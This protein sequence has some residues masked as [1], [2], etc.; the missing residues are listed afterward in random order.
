M[1][2][3]NYAALHLRP[4]PRWMSFLERPGFSH[5]T[6]ASPPEKEIIIIVAH[7]T[8]RKTRKDK[9]IPK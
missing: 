8:V 6:F 7:L 3:V 9:T 5:S 4:S 1:H 2:S